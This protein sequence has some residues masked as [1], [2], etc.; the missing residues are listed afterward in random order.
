MVCLG[1]ACYVKGA[2]RL[3]QEIEA[4]LGIKSGQTTEDGE[5]SITTARCIGACGIAPAAVFDGTVAPQVSPEQ[6]IA[7]LKTWQ[8]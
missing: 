6:A 2:D 3:L 4:K 5:V 7:K 1:T 8:T